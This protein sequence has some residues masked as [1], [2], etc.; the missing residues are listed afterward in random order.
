MHY[1][2]Y[3][4]DE[5]FLYQALYNMNRGYDWAATKSMVLYVQWDELPLYEMGPNYVNFYSD[6]DGLSPSYTCSVWNQP[7]QATTPTVVFRC[8]TTVKAV[9]LLAAM[10]SPGV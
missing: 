2:L 3:T 6:E 1:A 8:F 10:N 7:S 4:Y 5:N 9:P